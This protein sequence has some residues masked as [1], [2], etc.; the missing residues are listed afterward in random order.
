MHDD[1]LEDFSAANIARQLAWFRDM[2]GRLERIPS[3][4]AH[5]G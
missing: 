4:D 2:K 1:R 3:L 5:A